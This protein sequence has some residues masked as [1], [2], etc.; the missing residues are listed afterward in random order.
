MSR[1]E[2][3]PK[4]PKLMNGEVASQIQRSGMEYEKLFGV[5]LVH[6]R[7]SH[8]IT[9]LTMFWPEPLYRGVRETM[10]L[11]TIIADKERLSDEADGMGSG[12]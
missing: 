9:N 7:R 8:R 2:D 3:H 12:D 1:S 4:D 6:L 5:S 10:I 11:A